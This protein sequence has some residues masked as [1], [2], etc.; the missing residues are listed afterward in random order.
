MAIKYYSREWVEAVKK[1]METN[2]EYQA[3]VPDLTFKSQYVITDCP[4]GVD[5]LLDWTLEKGV[6]VEHSIEE[7]PAPSDFRTMPF[8]EDTYFMRVGGSYKTFGR[9]NRGEISPLQAVMQKI[10]NIQGPL[11]RIMALMGQLNY[12]NEI[13]ASVPCEYEEV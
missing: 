6:L 4:G 2:K 5:K 11:P 13:N 7:K 8:D 10:Y 1:N 12:L 9:M 3:K